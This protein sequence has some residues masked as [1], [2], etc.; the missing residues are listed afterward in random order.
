VVLV[1]DDDAATRT[2]IVQWLERAGIPTAEAPDGETAL[3]VVRDNPDAIDALVLD[4]MMPGVD[5]YEVLQVMQREAATAQV[6]VIILT[7]HATREVDVVRAVDGGAVDH[8]AKPFSGPVL[9]AKVRA[10]CERGRTDRRLRSKLAFA[11]SRAALDPLTR[12]FNRRAFERALDEEASRA[13]EHGLPLACALLDVDHFKSINDT[14]G[15]EAGDRVLVLLSE[16]VCGLLRKDD[17]ACRYGGEEF[18]LL[19]PRTPVPAAVELVGRMQR[20]LDARPMD[21]VGQTR[22][23]TFS[24]GVA[25]LDTGDSG[26][27]DGGLIARADAALYAAKRGGRN[28]IEVG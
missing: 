23:I 7:A 28:R 25:A 5:G 13:R 24:C 17:V 2:L 6:P 9:V 15:H 4:V 10:A 8:L 20:E 16:V 26:A 22:R 18:V 1:V 21:F 12:L 19:L 11:Q 14:F 27:G 3:A